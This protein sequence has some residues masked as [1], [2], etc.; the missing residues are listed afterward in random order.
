MMNKS[1]LLRA[2]LD[3]KTITDGKIEIYFTGGKF[4]YVADHYTVNVNDFCFKG[5][6][7]KKRCNDTYTGPSVKSYHF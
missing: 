7:V 2:M 6:R 3:G 4:L 1:E 5:W